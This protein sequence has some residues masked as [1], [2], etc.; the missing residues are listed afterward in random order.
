MKFPTIL[1]PVMVM[2]EFTRESYRVLLDTMIKDAHTELAM[3][4]KAY[5]LSSF[6]VVPIIVTDINFFKGRDGKFP[7]L[8]GPVLPAME[9][10]SFI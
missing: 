8:L 4:L 7:T 6:Y 9:L 2:E 10:Q 5:K 3:E 1:E